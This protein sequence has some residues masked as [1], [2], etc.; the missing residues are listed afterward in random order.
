MSDTA[1]EI[2]VDPQMAD[3]LREMAEADLPALSSLSIEAARAQVAQ[4]NLVWNQDPP[5]L[6]ATTDLTMQGPAGP[7]ALRH[8][9][10]SDAA[11][12]PLVI[13]LHGGGW[14]VCSLDTHDRLMRLLALDSN[15]AV[16]GVD[17]RL[18][19]EHPFPAP[20][21]DC[22]AAV[23]W[24]RSEA[25]SLGVDP[26]RIVLA[27]DSAGANLALASLLT[28]RDAGDPQVRG[29]ALF[30][31]CYWWRFDTPAHQRFGDGSWRLGT[32]EMRWFW[33]MYVGDGRPG[34]PLA[35]P[36]EADLRGLPPLFLTAAT[37]DPLYDDTLEL[38]RRLE[39]AG[40]PRRL[41]VYKGLV[42][43]FM[44]MSARCEAARDAIVDASQAIRRMLA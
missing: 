13:Y 27:G 35:E 22:V 31:G 44:Q 9:R 21:D 29:G 28:L 1:Q 36:I 16:I 7:I 19:P 4:G 6:Q 5:E 37:L 26:G 33:R 30:Y 25:R 32:A 14:A 18:A 2:Y 3:I 11:L 43:G 20:L 23:R 41:A 10:P 38:D 40:A 15:A 24:I 39:A 42:H 12:L 17:Y 34:N 8:Y